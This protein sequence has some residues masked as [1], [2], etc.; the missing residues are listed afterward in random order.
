MVDVWL[1]NWLFCKDAKFRCDSKS[2]LIKMNDLM[3]RVLLAVKLLK[4]NDNNESCFY[5]ISPYSASLA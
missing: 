4:R 3:A 1:I 2:P 5:H